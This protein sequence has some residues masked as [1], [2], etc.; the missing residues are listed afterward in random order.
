MIRINSGRVKRQF[1]TVTRL[2]KRH[3]HSVVPVL[4]GVVPVLVGG[5]LTR[6]LYTKVGI[7][8]SNTHNDN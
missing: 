8:R 1:T 3:S 2:T 4:V 7:K 6:Y 5:H